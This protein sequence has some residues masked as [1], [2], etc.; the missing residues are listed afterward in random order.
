MFKFLKNCRKNN[1]THKLKNWYIMKKN[2]TKST[3]KK[4]IAKV[5]RT[6]E[7]IEQKQ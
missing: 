2:N 5:T 3:G 4:Q 1:E 7:K 6:K